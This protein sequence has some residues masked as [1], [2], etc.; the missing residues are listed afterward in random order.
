MALSKDIYHALK[1]IVGREN[2]SKDPATL[3]AYA[4]QYLAELARPEQSRF[5]IRPEAVIMPGSTEEVQAI[6]KACNRYRI[7]V[8]P[9]STGWYFFGAPQS[10]GVV[11]LDLRR[12]DRILEIDE[13]NMIAVIEPYVICAT[14]QAEAMKVGLNCHMIG[15][16][17]STS[18]LGNSTSYAGPGP[19]TFFMGHNAENLLALEW[20]MPNG[21]ILRTGS[22]GSGAGCFCGEGPG[23]SLRG[24][25]R[26]VMGARGGMGVFTKCAVKLS[27]WPGPAVMPVEGTVPAYKTDLPDNFRGYSLSFP[28]WKAY[29]EAYYKLFDAEEVGYI[30]HRQF[31]KIGNELSAAF[32]MMYLD[33]TKTLDDIEEFEKRPEIQKLAEETKFSFEIVL[34]GHFPGDIDYQEKVLDKILADTGG[35]RITWGDAKE[36]MEK[37]TLLYMI[38]LGHKNLNFVFVGGYMGAASQVATPDNVI[39]YPVP[40]A[41]EQLSK[42]HKKGWLV[43]SGK[44]A[45]M[46]SVGGKGGGGLASLE[47]FTFYDTHDKESVKG[48]IAYMKDSAKA[49]FEGGIGPGKEFIY[50]QLGMTDEELE[51]GYAKVPQPSIFHWQ[52]KIKQMLD[53]NDT[54]DRLYPTLKPTK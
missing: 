21:D 51:A 10:E 39:Q 15:A 49:S 38:R 46:G 52:W 42:H 5:M 47:Q 48:E 50:L 9:Y 13:K 25:V 6:V 11:Q 43:N 33:P 14:L 28:N 18:I 35:H 32:W 20:V 23:P 44:D 53:P 41:I 8:K 37:F 2:I 12:M 26:G 40:I 54:G 29:A 19:G 45:M 34:A 36:D 16:G 22:L 17:A 31:N 3:D 30:A 1:E 4:F 7:K 24:I 27:P